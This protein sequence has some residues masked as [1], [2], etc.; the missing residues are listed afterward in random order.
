MPEATLEPAGDGT[1]LNGTYQGSPATY[2]GMKLPDDDGVSYLEYTRGGG[3]HS[4]YVDA[5]PPNAVSVD[6]VPTL[7]YRARKHPGD[8]AFGADFNNGVRL[9][10]SN[11]LEDDDDLGTSW[12]T[13]TTA[14]LSRPGGGSWDLA[15][16]QGAQAGSVEI[17]F[18]AGA[19]ANTGT[20]HNVTTAFL[21]VD[22]SIRSLR[23]TIAIFGWLPP[24][25][26]AAS[27][28]LSRREVAWLLR[29][30][31]TRPS[32]DHDFRRILEAFQVRPRFCF[33]GEGR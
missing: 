15:D 22:Y 7:T 20:R 9:S 8:S 19:A 31:K 12:V 5:L 25:I 21:T 1:L 24:L 33:V 29:N 17:V 4:V 3:A 23:A 26:A 11:T 14:A 6:S 13:T 32:N 18:T 2:A 16:F 30:L 27:H 28:C 10:G